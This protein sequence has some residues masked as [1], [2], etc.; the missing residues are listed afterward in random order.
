M[1]HRFKPK[2]VAGLVLLASVGG[3]AT[4]ALRV[5]YAKSVGTQGKEAAE[6]SKE[7]L[8]RVDRARRDANIELVAADPACGLDGGAKVRNLPRISAREPRGWLCVP[9]GWRADA[10][11]V[12]SLE[13]LAP[14]LE[15]T[16]DLIAAL[17]S[18]ADALAE[19]V[20]RKQ[21]DPMKPLID[22]LTTARAAQGAIQAIRNRE[23]GPIPAVDDPRVVAVGKFVGFLAELSHEADQVRAIREVLKK[24]PQG[25]EPLIASLREDLEEWEDSRDADETARLAIIDAIRDRAVLSNPPV[26]IAQRREA[27]IAFHNL[28]DE[29]LSAAKIHP[30]LD[31]ALAELDAADKD[32]RRVI[33]ENPRL[34]PK[35]R[36]RRAELNRQRIVRA[37]ELVTSLVTTFRGG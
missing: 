24:Y 30:A 22:A 13:P 4:N 18:Y 29:R 3:C 19:V 37:L 15:P 12:Y 6:A 31:D 25:P 33:V 14:E 9:P 7:F 11:T 23:G 35:E 10:H 17:A 16:L 36:K 27:L 21:P 20:D 8:R 28:E 2:A 1:F 34:T 26:S 32:L 5:E